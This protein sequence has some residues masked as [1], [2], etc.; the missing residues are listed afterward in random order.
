MLEK[1]ILINHF[2]LFSVFL[3]GQIQLGQNIVEEAPGDNFGTSI[4]MSADGNTIAIGAPYNDGNGSWS[5]HVRVYTYN[6]S[7]FN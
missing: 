5:G 2:I 4:S 3:L 7:G 1:Y 6:G